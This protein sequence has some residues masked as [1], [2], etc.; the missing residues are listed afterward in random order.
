[1]RIGIVGSEAAKFTP[2]TEEEARH[3]IRVMIEG[4]ELVISGECHLG[5]VDI[6]AKEEALAAGIPFLPCPPMRLQWNGGYKERNLKIAKCSDILV[7][8]T[9][10]DL[11]PGY[12]GMRFPF[13]YHHRDEQNVPPHVKSGGCWTLRQAKLMGK[14][15][16]LIVIGADA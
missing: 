4:A 9:V 1:M 15:T 3:W 11:P 6:Y 13:C 12:T 5:G 8:I 14:T 2:E 7:C 16:E 10:K